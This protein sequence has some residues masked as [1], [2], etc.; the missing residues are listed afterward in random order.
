MGAISITASGI[1]RTNTT[2]Y[3]YV[4]S[5]P[6]ENS[7]GLACPYHTWV[8]PCTAPVVML[9]VLGRHSSLVCKDSEHQESAR[10]TVAEAFVDEMMDLY[11]NVPERKSS[12]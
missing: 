12:G 4:K 3:V 8:A 1:I 2:A 7:Q 11:G 9:V 10:L 6:V 5:V